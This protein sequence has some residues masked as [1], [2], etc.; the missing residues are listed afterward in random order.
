[1]PTFTVVARQRAARWPLEWRLVSCALPAVVLVFAL[2][3]LAANCDMRTLDAYVAQNPRDANAYVARAQCLLAPQRSMVKPYYG[4]L[5]PA[6]KDLETAIR[7]DPD[8]AAAHYEYARTAAFEGQNELAKF[9]FSSAIRL[10]PRSA[11]SYA[12]RGWAE[13]NLCQTADASADFSRAVAL[14]RTAERE[15]ASPQAV[16]AQ[17]ARCAAPPPPPPPP[18]IPAAQSN[19][20]STP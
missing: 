4:N 9:R 19:T 8:N 6:A 1:M 18:P 7:L 16:A 14:D 2:P 15:V 13:F 12:G 10:D 5:V 3:A 17:R 20:G 11:R